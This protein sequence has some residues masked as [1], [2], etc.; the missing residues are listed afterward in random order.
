M[1]YAQSGRELA[2]GGGSTMRRK[3][4]ALCVEQLERWSAVPPDPRSIVQTPDTLGI[5]GRVVT[6]KEFR[7]RYE[8][9]DLADQALIDIGYPAKPCDELWHY[10]RLQPTTVENVDFGDTDTSKAEVLRSI[11]ATVSS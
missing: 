6:A 5:I 8:R 9:K 4:H 11:Q 10:L 3:I 7:E 1:Y 2:L